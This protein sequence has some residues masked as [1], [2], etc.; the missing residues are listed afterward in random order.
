MMLLLDIGNTRVKW[1]TL[2]RGQLST[3]LP[4][5]HRGQPLPSLWDTLWHDLP[6]PQRLVVASVAPPE[7]N[8]SLLAWASSRWAITPEFASSAAQACGVIN[9]YRQPEKLGVDRWL[10]L[11][12]ARQLPRGRPLCVIDCGTALTVDILATDGMHL[13]GWISPG[14]DMMRQELLQ[15]AALLSC[16]MDEMAVTQHGFGRTTTEALL[17]GTEQAAAGLVTRALLLTQNLLGEVPVCVITGG[18]AEMLLQL[19]PPDTLIVS[20]LVLRGLAALMKHQ[21]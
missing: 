12:G 13:G 9:G 10:A 15:G 4:M 1:A 18:G 20:D 11:I 17:I 19:L 21:E 3:G 14:L 16:A 8:A 7:V 2:Q 6:A 5:Q